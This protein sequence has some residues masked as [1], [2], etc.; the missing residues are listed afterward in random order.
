ML[1]EQKTIQFYEKLLIQCAD[2]GDIDQFF[3][4]QD[5][6]IKLKSCQTK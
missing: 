6:L 3:K 1:N 2:E 5:I 4:I